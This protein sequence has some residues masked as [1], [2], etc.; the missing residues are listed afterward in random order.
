MAIPNRHRVYSPFFHKIITDLKNNSL[1]INFKAEGF[2]KQEVIDKCKAYENLLEND[3]LS[4]KCAQDERFVII[5]PHAY[6]KVIGLPANS[7][8][9]LSMAVQLYGKNLVQLSPFIKTI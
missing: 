7:Y 9:F 8:R 1:R 6:P 2:T 5:L 4:D 3:P